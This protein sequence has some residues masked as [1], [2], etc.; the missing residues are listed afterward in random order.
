VVSIFDYWSRGTGFVSLL[1]HGDV[2]VIGE[3]PHG[4]HGL[5]I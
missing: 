2:F 1:Y 5:G 3:V 4:D